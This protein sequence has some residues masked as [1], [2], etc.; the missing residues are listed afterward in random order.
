MPDIFAAHP[1]PEVKFEIEED[2]LTK[3]EDDFQV[4]EE[5]G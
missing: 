5:L 2:E 4:D 1:H 3:N